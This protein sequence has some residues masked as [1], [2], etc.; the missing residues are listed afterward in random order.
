MALLRDHVRGTLFAALAC[1]TACGPTLTEPTP[2]GPPELQSIR[3]AGADAAMTTAIKGDLK[4]A[5]VGYVKQKVDKLSAEDDFVVRSAGPDMDGMQHVRMGQFH[6]GV[7]VFGGSVVVHASGAQF[8][9]MSGNVVT[10]LA[11]F[12]VVP[13]V[14]STAALALAKGDY[15]SKSKDPKAQL[16]FLR[17]TSELVI[18]PEKTGRQATLAWHVVF[19]T[20]LQAGLSPGLWNYFYDAKTGALIQMFNGIDTLSQAS[21]PGGN[22]KVTRTWVN[23]LDVEPSGA[24]FQMNTARLITGDMGH[25]TSGN[26]TI[27]VGPLNPIGDAPIND[28][29]GFAEETLNML[30][31]WQGYNSI[32]NA[33]FVIRSRVHYSTNYENAFWDGTEMTY[34][35]GASTFFPLSGSVDVV[36]HEIDHGFTSFHSDLIYADQSGGM[37]ESF[38]DIAGEVTEAHF[39]NAAPDF[40][41]G[42]DIFRADSAL[43]FMCNPTQ[44]GISIDNAA[45]MTPSLDP[46]FSSG[47]MNKAFCLTARR[48]ATGAPQGPATKD[49]VKRAS[50]AWYLANAQFWVAGSTFL[51]GCQGVY[52]AATSLGFSAAELLIIR[53]SWLDVGVSCGASANNMAPTVSLTAPADGSTVSGTIAVSAT[54]ADV[55]GVVARVKFTF[56]DGSTITD[57]SAPFATTWNSGAVAN[58]PGKVITAVATDDQ[59]ATAT[60]TVTVTVSNDGTGTC[61]G[62]TVQAAGLPVSI[63]DNNTAGVTSTLP[64]LGMGNI[65]TL[66]L[67]LNIS[68]T[69]RGDL[70]VTLISP[71][72]AS[73]VVSNRAGG[74]ADNLIITDQVI[75]T[76]NGTPGAGTWSL[77]VQDLAAADVGTI[78]SWSLTL[79]GDCTGGG[80]WSGS[81]TP[82]LPTVDN[83]S[84]CTGLTVTGGTGDATTA[85]LDIAGQH[86]F[87]SILR[88]TLA[89][90][91]VTVTAFP[92]NT[93]PRAAGLFSFTN[94]SIGGLTGDPNGLWT[95]CIIDT[96]GF[97]DT[98]VLNTWSVHN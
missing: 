64:I 61:V 53:Q 43:R 31:E 57:T 67:S 40:D 98:G 60:S 76:F 96:D 23:Q 54:A 62:G 89:H 79:T 48:L 58:G 15:A 17:E 51:Q 33:G 73:F 1:T 82:N 16:A 84:A 14:E 95:L 68:H 10:N 29:H 34:G 27:V 9:S 97:G 7:R 8:H 47:V 52:D 28:A 25:A 30:Q 83:G 18:L 39:K 36:G 12:D 49:S 24:Q 5:A 46:H 94:R 81:A 21:G 72:G 3:I 78:N 6:A 19:F 41:V 74:S 91:G 4:V 93:L 22:P 77:K 69:F 59:G 92:V 37:N 65:A 75:P 13:T 50:N 42:R 80:H 20:E 32:D 70:V 71:T 86:Q 38:S 85:K 26:G 35:D 44:D 87:R 63:P 2:A 11:N 55:D 56:P 90:N 45:N 66:S 88:G